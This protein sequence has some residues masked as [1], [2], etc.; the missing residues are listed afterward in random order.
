MVLEYC[1]SQM[2]PREKFHVYEHM[3]DIYIFVILGKQ[4]KK[5]SE[6]FFNF[7]AQFNLYGLICVSVMQKNIL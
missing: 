5:S 2:I 6:F 3:A 4:E 1:E 7:Y